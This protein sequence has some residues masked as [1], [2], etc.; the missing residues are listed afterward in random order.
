[1]TTPRVINCYGQRLATDVQGRPGG[2][3]FAPR[4]SLAKVDNYLKLI[5]IREE[6]PAYGDACGTTLSFQAFASVKYSAAAF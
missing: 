6:I 5:V 3:F 4:K 2:N 1:M